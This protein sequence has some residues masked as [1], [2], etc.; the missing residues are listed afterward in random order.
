MKNNNPMTAAAWNTAAKPIKTWNKANPDDQKKLPSIDR[1]RARGWML[2]INAEK[3]DRAEVDAILGSVPTASVYSEEAGSTTGYRHY[4]AFAYW[5][6]KTTGSRVRALFGDAHCEP[7]GKPAVACAAYCSKD[8]TH[9][10]GPYWLGAYDT[11][12]GM[13][14]TTEQVERKSKFSE[15]QERIEEGWQYFDFL[16]SSEWIAWALRHKQAIQDLTELHD[17]ETYG[18]HDREVSVDYIWGPAGSGKTISILD[19]FGRESVFIA[20]ATNAFPFDGYEGE[21]VLLL[22]DFRSSLRFEYLLR[23]LQGQPF[24]VNVKGSHT[25]AHWTK[26]VIS[27]NIPLSEQYPNLSE[28]KDPLLRRFESGIVFEKTSPAVAL[29]YASREDAMKGIRN[30]GG[31]NGVQGYTPMWEREQNSGGFSDSDFDALLN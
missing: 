9:L 30:D 13:K 24:L 11:V 25:L 18:K 4:Q 8:K 29:P 20:D 1:V 5:E 23:V 7:A 31:Q 17:R 10:S 14:P 21:S 22:D 16:G 15:A 12:P 26:V 19:A 6:G 28:R 3:H 27:A 2:T